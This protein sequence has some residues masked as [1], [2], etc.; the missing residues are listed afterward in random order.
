MPVIATPVEVLQLP[1][2]GG[3]TPVCDLPVSDGSTTSVVKQTAFVRDMVRKQQHDRSDECLDDCVI[4]SSQVF[5][6][7]RA[8][9]TIRSGTLVQWDFHPHF[10]DPGPHEFQLQVG[11]TGANEADDW[12]PVGLPATNVFYM[13]DDER[14]VFGKTQW[15]HYRV[16]LSTPLA[17]YF[18]EPVSA[19]GDLKFGDRAIFMELLRANAKYLEGSD[20]T[21]G[22]LLKKRKHGQRCTSCTDLLTED[23]RSTNCPECFGT[24][25]TQGW[26]DPVPCIWAAIDP[27]SSHNNVDNKMQ[28]GTVDDGTRSLARMLA[29][30]QLFEGDVWVDYKND[31][32]YYVHELRDHV[33]WRNVTVVY[34][35]ELRLLP[36]SDPAYLIEVPQM[37]PD[38][39]QTT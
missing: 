2:P 23:V 37:L 25:F 39:L 17:T 31:F 15:T 30:P 26:F 8:L 35:A 14:R 16:C 13:I 29:V 24:G 22:A 38:Q 1:P 10:A 3:A 4:T 6:N 11:R 20:G 33:E 19:L 9:P 5:V 32:R 12:T 28:R 21:V 18:S 27:A 36:F 34:R 7:L